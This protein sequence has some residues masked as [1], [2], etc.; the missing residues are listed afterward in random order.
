[1]SVNTKQS[2]RSGLISEEQL[3]SLTNSAQEM[4]EKA[5]MS[6]KNAVEKSVNFTKEYP[7]HTAVGA[8]VVGFFAG[9]IINKI[10][11]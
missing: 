11:K 5:L 7:I 1:M 6:S 8:G 2:D 4:S 10:L 9:A 3:R